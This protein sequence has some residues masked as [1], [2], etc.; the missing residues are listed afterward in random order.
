VSRP[1]DFFGP[2]FP[3]LNLADDRPLGHC[4]G[5]TRPNGTSPSVVGGLSDLRVCT[6]SYLHIRV[7]LG[8]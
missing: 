2:K 3:Y 8:P 6:A 4:F 1:P 7:N 5:S